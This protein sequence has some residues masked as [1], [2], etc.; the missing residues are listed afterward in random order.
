[1]TFV[2]WVPWSIIKKKGRSFRG[3]PDFE[4]FAV[5]YVIELG[6]PKFLSTIW[7]SSRLVHP[8]R[9]PLALD[10]LQSPSPESTSGIAH[11]VKLTDHGG[12]FL[13][14]VLVNGRLVL[15]FVLD[16]GASEV[17]IPDDVLRTLYR[18]GTISDADFLG[19]ETY[20]LADGSRVP[21]ARFMLHS[22]EVGGHTV[23]NVAA[24]VGTMNSEPLLGQ[25]FLSKLGSWTLDNQ[26]HV[27]VVR[28]QRMVP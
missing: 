6:D 20:T 21:S 28:T 15:D 12:T 9:P 26:R 8:G 4:Q 1:V 5:L 18:T 11:E 16:S 22:L 3:N 7:G 13:V 10:L 19:T 17:Q 2:N 14:P 25:S 24:S 23:S 27:L